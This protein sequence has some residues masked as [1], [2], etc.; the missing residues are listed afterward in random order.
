MQVKS[1]DS[2][3]VY[4]KNKPARNEF[5]PIFF[6]KFCYLFAKLRFMLYLFKSWDIA[7]RVQA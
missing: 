1:N 2:K 5:I 7:E 4:F 3:Y 6:L